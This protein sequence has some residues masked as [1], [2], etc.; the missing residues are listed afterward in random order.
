MEGM[1]IQRGEQVLIR[2]FG[3]YPRVRRLWAVA[4]PA[5]LVV[6]D[7]WLPLV[8]QGD[9]SWTVGV[10]IEDVFRYDPTVSVDTT[11]P[12]PGWDKLSSLA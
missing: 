8:E 2:T 5:C 1:E 4:P 7:A 3:G 6:E 12:Y 10:P 9:E 11:R